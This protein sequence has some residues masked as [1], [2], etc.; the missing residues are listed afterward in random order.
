MGKI[1]GLIGLL[2]ALACCMPVLSWAQSGAPLRVYRVGPADLPWQSVLAG[3]YRDREVPA[4]KQAFSPMPETSG[5]WRVEISRDLD[6]MSDPMLHLSAV[7]LTRSEVWLPGSP[8]PL[9]FSQLERQGNHGFSPRLMVVALPPETRAGDSVYWRVQTGE[10]SPL[11]LGLAAED[12]LRVQ[13]G[14]Q[15]RWHSMVEG[16]IL[17]LVLAGFVLSLIMRETT[18][19]ILAAGIF[20]SLLFVLTNNGD[21]FYY[22]PLAGLDAEY[23]LQRIMGLAACAVMTYFAYIFLDMRRRTPRLAMVQRAIIGAFLLLL[24][25]S[26]LPGFR[27]N[28]LGS[29]LGNLV[30]VAGTVNGILASILLIRAGQRAGKLYLLSWTPLLVFSFWRIVEISLRLPFNEFVSLAF[31]ATYVLAGILLYLGLGERILLYK[32]ERDANEHLARMDSLTEVY[33]RRALDERLRI[34]AVQT[35][36]SGRS[37]AVLFADLDHFKRINDSYGHDVGDYVLKDVTLRIRSVLR[38]G[39]VL[40]RYGGEEFVIALPD[41]GEEQARQLAE[42]IRERIAERP[43]VCAGTFIPVTVSI[44]IS[45][46]RDG[47]S[48]IDGAL[49]RADQ[50]LYFCKQNG[51]NC[52][53][54]VPA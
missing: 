8:A 53:N 54:T 30:I 18:F 9:R 36:K 46:L 49:K 34:A 33:N 38:F 26:F 28:P 14:Q 17:A 10:V 1:R 21:V 15:I 11:K 16:T 31:P 29:V 25:G 24:I 47:L 52:V 43:V 39:D 19:L 5:W 32:R 4:G 13:D 45:V 20:L 51:R 44:G 37:M 48:D 22:P 2:L 7:S 12:V 3:K 27:D 23:A 35:E 6:R 41:C 50:A 42:R 40:G